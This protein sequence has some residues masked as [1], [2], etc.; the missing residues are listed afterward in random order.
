M[1]LVFLIILYYYFR[2]SP[3]ISQSYTNNVDEVYVKIFSLQAFMRIILWQYHS[4]FFLLLFIHAFVSPLFPF[5]LIDPCEGIGGGGGVC[6]RGIQANRGE[7][8]RR[9]NQGAGE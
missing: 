9:K 5:L 1:P 6:Y 2:F 3:P 8:R 7:V 4:I